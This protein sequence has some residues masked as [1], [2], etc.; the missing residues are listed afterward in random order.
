MGA[1]G[2]DID[3]CPVEDTD[4]NLDRP[5]G[6]A[7]GVCHAGLHPSAIGT[8]CDIWSSLHGLCGNVR[9]RLVAHPGRVGPP[10]RMPARSGRAGRNRFSGGPEN[11]RR[12]ARFCRP[13]TQLHRHG[14]GS[15][16][17]ARLPLHGIGLRHASVTACRRDRHLVNAAIRLCHPVGRLFNRLVDHAAEEEPRRRRTRPRQDRTDQWRVDRI[18]DSDERAAARLF[19]GHAGRQGTGVRCS[20]LAGTGARS[21]DRHGRRSHSEREGHEESGWCGLL[22]CHRSG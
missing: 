2:T 17:R 4:C 6:R 22:D 14:V 5:R 12:N 15:G 9:P 1:R 13:D 19:K 10:G 3:R 20:A 18:V 16:L 11:D 8:A 7:C 21:H